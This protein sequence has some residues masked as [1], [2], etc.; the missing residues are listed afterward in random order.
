MIRRT[1]KHGSVAGLCRFL[2]L[3]MLFATTT[4]FGQEAAGQRSAARSPTRWRRGSR[5]QVILLNPGHG[6]GRNVQS[7]SSAG[8]YTFVSLN[9]GEYRVTAS[10]TGFASVALTKVTVNVDA[11]H[12]GRHRVKGGRCHR[13]RSPSRKDRPTCLSRPTRP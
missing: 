6:S 7:A 1:F 4:A 8:L 13:L 12:R 9:P 5:S 11:D 3:A 10:Q 2:V